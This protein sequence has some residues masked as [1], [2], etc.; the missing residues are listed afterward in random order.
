MQ[1]EKNLV[2]LLTQTNKIGFQCMHHI[3]TCDFI[4]TPYTENKSNVHVRSQDLC[5]FLLP[6]Q[7]IKLE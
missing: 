2:S 5:L 1:K 6:S 7:L 4:P 3:C